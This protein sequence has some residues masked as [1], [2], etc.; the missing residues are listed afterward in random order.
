ME[1]KIP[2]SYLIAEEV[3]PRWYKG[4]FLNIKA[5]G[6]KQKG[7]RF[8]QIV[9]FL[10][11]GEKTKSSDND[12]ILD[13][14]LF[15][16]KGSTVTR[17][18]DEC[19]SFLQIRPN[20]EYDYLILSSFHFD[21]LIE[22]FKIPKNDVYKLISGKIFKKQHEGKNGKSETYCYNGTME[23]FSQYKFMERKIVN[24]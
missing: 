9:R 4:P 13:N 22:L 21:G 16:I 17:G 14:N 20:Q 3:D 10:M 24:G 7:K 2:E 11:N 1:M 12:M 6:A 5:M 15:E 19:F 23:P 8:E 18:T